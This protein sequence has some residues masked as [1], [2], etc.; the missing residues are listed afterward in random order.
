MLI[1]VSRNPTP[2]SKPSPTW[3]YTVLDP[4]PESAFVVLDNHW[5]V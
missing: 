2:R 5:L 4:S 1:S 3:G